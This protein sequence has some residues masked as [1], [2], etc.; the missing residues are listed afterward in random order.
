MGVYIYIYNMDCN[1]HVDESITQQLNQ[2][3]QKETLHAMHALI[4]VKSGLAIYNLF[5]SS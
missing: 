1:L 2:Q 3:T 4:K 5:C